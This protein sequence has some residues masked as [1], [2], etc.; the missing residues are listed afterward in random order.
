MPSV[1]SAKTTPVIN[2]KDSLPPP[3]AEAIK[4]DFTSPPANANIAALKAFNDDFLKSHSE[5]PTHM[6]RGYNVRFHLD[7]SSKTQNEKDLQN[8]L[9]LDGVTLEQA[10]EGTALLQEWK[11][12]TKTLDA[13]R[14]AAAKKWPQ[15]AIFQKE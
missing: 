14:D 12:D 11:S 13:Y 4:Q 3:V 2:L 10:L 6:Q 7:P 1:S 8:L 9:N 15:A 5:S